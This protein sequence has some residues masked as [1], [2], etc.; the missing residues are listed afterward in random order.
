MAREKRRIRPNKRFF[1]IVF[2]VLCVFCISAFIKQRAE[3]SRIAQER[4]EIQA[5][6]DA[7]NLEKSELTYILSCSQT[8]EYIQMI[9][10]EKLGWVTP[11]ET[12]F[13]E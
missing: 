7:A 8:A 1:F 9:A 6:L 5:A 3:L 10:R 11:E 2:L 4:E 13:E 12:R